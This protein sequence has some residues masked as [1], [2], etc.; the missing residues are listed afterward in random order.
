MHLFS[1][2]KKENSLTSHLDDW[3]GG[4]AGKREEFIAYGNTPE[5]TSINTPAIS[6]KTHFESEIQTQIQILRD[7]K[8]M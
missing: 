6:L 8:F 2:D 5:I 3:R 1:L 7:L 4:W